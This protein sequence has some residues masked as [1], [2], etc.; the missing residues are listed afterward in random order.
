[1]KIQL[2][3]FLSVTFE[4]GKI[5][6]IIVKDK[7][8]NNMKNKNILFVLLMGFALN[9][10]GGNPVRSDEPSLKKVVGDKFHIGVAINTAQSSGRDAKSVQLIKNILILL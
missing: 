2:V 9:S 6:E 3:L 4:T 5:A 8:E 1:M 10:W 7:I